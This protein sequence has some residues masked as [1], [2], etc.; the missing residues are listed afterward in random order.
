MSQVIS[1]I[2]K[3]KR[4]RKEIFIRAIITFIAS[5]LVNTLVG[6]L[7]S[8]NDSSYFTFPFVFSLIYALISFKDSSGFFKGLTCGLVALVP[9][10]ILFLANPTGVY[11]FHLI[12]FLVIAWGQNDLWRKKE[13]S[14]Y[15]T[16]LIQKISKKTKENVQTKT[17]QIHINIKS[18]DV[19]K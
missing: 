6:R 4:E 5:L 18:K 14:N 1:R 9:G 7:F 2:E 12:M 15:Y 16:D 17:R 19:K 8:D 10:L 3:K 13:I 11:F